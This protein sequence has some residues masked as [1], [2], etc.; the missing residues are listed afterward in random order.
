VLIELQLS[1]RACISSRDGLRII[2]LEH[3]KSDFG[4]AG[5]YSLVICRF[6][7]SENRW[8]DG[9]LVCDW[10]KKDFKPQTQAQADSGK[11]T[12][13]LIMDRHSSHYSANLL[14]FCQQNNI[15]VYGYPSHCTHALQ[16]L[17]VICF[18]KMKKCWKEELNAFENLHNQRCQ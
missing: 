11:K 9:G 13:A 15:E 16:G 4:D 18:A 10:I 2:S 8:T 14:E 6:S 1:L 17:D 12:C 3:H 7:I 5:A